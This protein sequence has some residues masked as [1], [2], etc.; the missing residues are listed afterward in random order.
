M[1]TTNKCNDTINEAS[2]DDHYRQ[3]AIRSCEELQSISS[4]QLQDEMIALAR[5]RL[6]GDVHSEEVE[7][8]RLR[9]VAAYDGMYDGFSAPS[10]QVFAFSAFGSTA[11][12]EDPKVA[13][14]SA[15][16]FQAK[17]V[18]TAAGE[19]DEQ[20][21]DEVFESTYQLERERQEKQWG[22]I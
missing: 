3:I 18:A 12:T 16:D 5:K 21:F 9:T 2:S 15:L 4:G 17:A 22:R 7:D 6:N 20:N 11:F 8:L 10:S 13:A 1:N 14:R 19:L